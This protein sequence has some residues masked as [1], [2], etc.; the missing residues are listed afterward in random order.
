MYCPAKI[1]V[2]GKNETRKISKVYIL[3]RTLLIF[4]IIIVNIM[5]TCLVSL[6]RL[7]GYACTLSP[8]GPAISLSTYPN[9]IIIL[10][11]PFI[12]HSHNHHNPHHYLHLITTLSPLG[13]AISLST[14]PNLILTLKTSF[15]QHSYNHHKRHH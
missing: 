13:R 7:P 8:L 2:P 6:I 10:K 15:V 3:M 11:T 4:C 14:F 12:Q 1:V 9:I 5:R